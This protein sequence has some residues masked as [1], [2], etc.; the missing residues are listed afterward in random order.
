MRILLTGFEP[1]GGEKINPSWE[2]I[3]SYES[4]K[5]IIKKLQLPVVF[6][7]SSLR[8]MKEINIF[9]PEYVLMFGEAGG[10][11]CI[12]L[13]RIGI[14]IINALIPDNDGNKPINEKI[15]KNNKDGIFSSLPIELINKELNLNNIPSYI[16]NSA[17]TYVC[18]NVLFET[19]N[20][21]SENNLNIKAGFIHVPY[22]REQI[23]EEK[24]TKPFVEI[25]L[26]TSA[27]EIILNCL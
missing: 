17:G 8:I 19:L 23:T 15:I 12:S 20:Y 1:F 6:R 26:L 13:E 3:K 4:K 21:I 24:S 27:L 25:S 2:M 22:I 7:K 10:R 9:H 18:N 5:F 16:S 14:N 11:N